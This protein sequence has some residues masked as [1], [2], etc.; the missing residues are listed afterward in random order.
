MA[1]DIDAGQIYVARRRMRLRER[2]VRDFA[3]LSRS[4]ISIR[5]TD[6]IRDTALLPDP[7]P[8]VIA[9]ILI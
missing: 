3:G 2:A 9:I 7:M 8:P 1:D 6:S 5:I 4:E